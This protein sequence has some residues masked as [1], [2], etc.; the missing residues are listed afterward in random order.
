MTTLKFVKDMDT[1]FVS[2]LNENQVLVIPVD[3]YSIQRVRLNN[4]NDHF[5]P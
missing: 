3:L 5:Q 2:I 4:T 1:S